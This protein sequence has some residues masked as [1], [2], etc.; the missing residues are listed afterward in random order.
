MLAPSYLPESKHKLLAELTD[1]LDPQALSWLS[2]YFAGLEQSGP[3]RRGA[4]PAISAVAVPDVAR[5]LTIVFGSQTGNAKRVAETLADR[6]ASLDMNVRLVR[7]DRY[8]TRELKDEHL[9]YIVMSTQ[10]EGEPP[11][12]SMS[13]VEFLSSRRAPKLPHLKYAVLGL[14]DSSYPLFCGIA[15]SIDA[16]LGELGAERIH[17]LGMADLDIETVASPWQDAAVALAQK[18]LKQADAPSANVTPLYPKAAAV[19]RDQPFLAE[20]LQNQRITG[21]G[22]DKDVRHLEI[23][24]EDCQL[25]YQPGDAL[26]VWPRQSP[27]LVQAVIA[28]LGLDARET[29]QINEVARSLE[30]WLTDHREL[31]QLTKPFL[32]AHAERA[33]SDELKGMLQADALDALKAYLGSRQLLDVLKAHP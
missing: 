14:G 11:D 31:T 9:L 24:L 4:A 16:R 19:S 6:V 21:R 33:D 12:D 8:V 29:V 18:A 5:R 10:G 27:L 26:G 20:L 22:S 2:G 17:G 15:Q 32:T 1:G 30:E 25:R 7:A 3:A 28:E 23:S 13:F